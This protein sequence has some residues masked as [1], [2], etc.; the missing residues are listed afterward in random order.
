ML[1]FFGLC[2]LSYV[3]YLNSRPQK[4]LSDASEHLLN[5]LLG[6]E[7]TQVSGDIKVIDTNQRFGNATINFSGNFS[8]GILVTDSNRYINFSASLKS[9]NNQAE[10]SSGLFL[11]DN[12]E[13]FIKLNDLQKTLSALA[14][15]SDKP[16]VADGLTVLQGVVNKYQNQWLKYT[17]QDLEVFYPKVSKPTSS[18]CEGGQEI[19]GLNE[20]EFKKI[21]VEYTKHPFINIKNYQKGNDLSFDLSV[22]KGQLD[23]FNKAVSINS[24]L[25]KLSEYLTDTSK[26]ELTVNKI[27]HKPEVL[28]ITFNEYKLQTILNLKFEKVSEKMPAKPDSKL[29]LKDFEKELEAIIGSPLTTVLNDET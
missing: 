26:I 14:S 5:E 23:A 24:N 20:S 2:I 4:V 27:T 18:S 13:K 21:K 25:C 10:L 28:K 17:N 8:K 29:T 9:S 12:N 7:S 19:S 11:N 15:T 16:Y 1:L 3:Y 22:N 6:T